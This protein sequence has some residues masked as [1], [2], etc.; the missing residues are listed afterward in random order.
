MLLLAPEVKGPVSICSTRVRIKGHLAGSTV[1]VFVNG[2]QTSSKPSSWP[3]DVFDVGTALSAGDKITA[4]QQ[5]GGDTSPQSPLPA[6]VQ[7]VPATLASLTIITDLHS[8]GSALWSEGAVPGADVRVIINGNQA[9]SATSIDGI[10]RMKYS[11]VLNT[12]QTLSLQQT[13][14]T[15]LTNVTD[16][17]PAKALPNPLPI[18]AIEPLIECMTA[19]K[20]SK[21]IDGATVTLYRNSVKDAANVFDR[22]SLTWI[23]LKPLKEG[24]LIEVDQSFTCGRRV[25]P[26]TGASDPPPTH[27]S[28][29]GSAKVQSVANLQKP[30]ILTPVCPDP[31]LITISNLLPSARVILYAD[32]VEVGMTDTPESTF[33]FSAPPLGPNAKLTA[34]MQL[35]GKDG[36]LSSAVEVQG[37]KPLNKL[38]VSKLYECSS[39]IFIV[40]WTALASGKI[41]YAMNKNG[42][43]ISAYHQVFTPFFLFPVSPALTAG[44]EIRIVVLGCSGAKEDFGPFLVAPLEQLA[45]PALHEP[46]TESS[47]G[48]AVYSG[49][50]GA[51]IEVYV[52]GA[53]RAQGVSFGDALQ[54]FMNVGQPPLQFGQTVTAR[55]SF[56]GEVSKFSKPVTVVIPYPQPPQLIYPAKFAT[57]IPAQPTTFKWKDP[58]ANTSAAATSFQLHVYRDSDSSLAFD[59][60]GPS[61]QADAYLSYSSG[62]T[63]NVT[64]FNSTGARKSTAFTFETVAA[65]EPE[66]EPPPQNAQVTFVSGLYASYDGITLVWPLPGNTAFYLCI[67]VA[68]AGNATSDPFEIVFSWDGNGLNGTQT[69][70]APAASPG[71]SDVAFATFASGLPEGYYNFHAALVVNGTAI[72]NTSWIQAWVGF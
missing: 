13:T 54:T 27:I 22:P 36:P 62:F 64:A 38:Q 11:P 69:V 33:S 14:C 28:G 49:V 18:P 60:S 63:W 8:C 15:G 5:F 35:C 68:N 24:E 46:I 43:I 10:A 34:R 25:P 32:G 3:D 7:N 65:P 61:L 71:W 23:G 59:A 58:G 51:I 39:Y 50:A 72:Q 19:I 47:T 29:K 31:I 41:V 55:Q 67:I 12:N 42:D 21:I 16:S 44:D 57:G 9:G 17:Q 52:D 37:D 40:H 45:Q 56:C 66:E 1:S 26:E 20:I 2:A 53:Y 70:S 4:T 48:I 30:V 6:I